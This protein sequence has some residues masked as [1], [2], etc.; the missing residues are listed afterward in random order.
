MDHIREN[1]DNALDSAFFS[2]VSS[3]QSK[4]YFIDF[5]EFH[6]NYR[7][8]LYRSFKY[9]YIDSKLL[10]NVDVKNKC[11]FVLL[12]AIFTVLI[13]YFSISFNFFAMLF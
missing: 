9:L 12:I 5:K 4:K 2:R 8:I 6:V 11:L 7:I 13:Y 3:A 1:I 10:T